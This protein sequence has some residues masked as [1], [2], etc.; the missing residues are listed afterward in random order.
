MKKNPK[1]DGIPHGGYYT[2]EEIKEEPTYLNSSTP[3]Y[4]K[5][6]DSESEAEIKIEVTSLNK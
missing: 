2:Q 1:F 4:L 3:H 5:P 6:S